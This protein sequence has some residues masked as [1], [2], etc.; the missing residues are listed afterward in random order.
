MVKRA[1]PG[2]ALSGSASPVPQ[3]SRKRQTMAAFSPSVRFPGAWLRS[4]ATV[5]SPPSA[6]SE[7][8]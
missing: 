7:R 8:T 3:S 2:A 1:V 4:T 6:R 5:S